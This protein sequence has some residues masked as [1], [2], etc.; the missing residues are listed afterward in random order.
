MLLTMPERRGRPRRRARAPGP[1][2]H[3]G[4]MRAVGYVR[5]STTDQAADGTSL[6]VHRVLVIKLDRLAHSTR[7]L[8]DLYDRLEQLGV[9]IVAI[10]DSVDTT[11]PVGRLPQTVPAAADELERETIAE[12][13]HS[14]RQARARQSADLGPAPASSKRPRP[15]PCGASS[16]CG[17]V[18]PLEG[19]LL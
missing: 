6:G 5:V 12:R 13:V 18:A 17:P 4:P 16:A 9:G 14:G 15:T 1:L 8:L 10:R 19:G 2:A 11:T 7:N 3:Q